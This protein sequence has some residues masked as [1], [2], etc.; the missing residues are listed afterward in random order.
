MWALANCTRTGALRAVLSALVPVV[1]PRLEQQQHPSA[2]QPFPNGGVGH[3]HP[4]TCYPE[5]HVYKP[6]SFPLQ[7]Q[8]MAP[9]YAAS[10]HPLPTFNYSLQR[11]P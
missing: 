3:S 8:P 7:S 6:S 11:S 2:T 4:Q 5:E 9:L 1:T 10:I